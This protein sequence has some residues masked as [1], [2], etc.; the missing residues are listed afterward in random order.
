MKRLA[1]AR[2]DAERATSRARDVSEGARSLHAPHDP[3]RRGFRIGRGALGGHAGRPCWRVAP[4]SRLRGPGVGSETVGPDSVPPLTKW[5]CTAVVATETG[6]VW[7]KPRPPRFTHQER[8][9][10]HVWLGGTVT[11][12]SNSHYFPWEVVMTRSMNL[13]WRRGA[14]LLSVM[15]LGISL[16]GG[17]PALADDQKV[18]MQEGQIPTQHSQE[19]IHSQGATVPTAVSLAFGP[20]IHNRVGN[21]GFYFPTSRLVPLGTS[22]RLQSSQFTTSG[23]VTVTYTAECAVGA[24]AG[25]TTTWLNVD[26]E[27]VNV[28]THAVIGLAPTN[29]INDALCTADGFAELGGWRMSSITGVTTTLPAGTYVAQ[30]RANLQDAP[31]GAFGWLGD[32]T[33]IIRK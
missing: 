28:A 2:I 23:V 4:G 12:S 3:R 27:L 24:P 7:E 29:Q 9:E 22:G 6:L 25:N 16:G 13:G 8:R 21:Y 11:G 26:L 1:P 18:D 19:A 33:L 5:Y 10:R 17:Q 31:A 30:V 20:V 15:L 14:V 32:T